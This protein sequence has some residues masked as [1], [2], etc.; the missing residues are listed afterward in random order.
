L[1]VLTETG[2]R[3]D[4]IKR[5]LK[6]LHEEQKAIERERILNAQEIGLEEAQEIEEEGGRTQG[7]NDSL[8]KF[9]YRQA[10][11]FDGTEQAEEDLKEAVNTH[12]ELLTRNVSNLEKLLMSKEEVE[13]IDQENREK[14]LKDRS[15]HLNAWTIRTE[16]ESIL[17][18]FSMQPGDFFEPIQLAKIRNYIV[19]NRQLITDNLFEVKDSHIEKPITFIRSYYKQLGISLDFRIKSQGKGKARF[20]LYSLNEQSK[21]FILRAIARRQSISQG[22]SLNSY[23]IYTSKNPVIHLSPELQENTEYHQDKIAV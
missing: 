18:G 12:L 6:A 9:K 8:L 15:Y 5:E 19:E 7:Q 11:G 14:Y 13:A 2:E 16:I 21:E 4:K 1:D 20:R 10:I 3:Q 17:Q 23:S 22:G